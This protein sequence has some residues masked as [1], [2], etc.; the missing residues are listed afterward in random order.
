[1]GLYHYSR[2]FLEGLEAKAGKQLSRKVGSQLLLNHRGLKVKILLVG[3]GCLYQS[4]Q[5]MSPG[6][7]SEE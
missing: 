1:M 4:A 7:G 6:E 3:L 5:E 2:L